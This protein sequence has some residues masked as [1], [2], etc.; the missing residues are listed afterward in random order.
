MPAHGHSREDTSKE[1]KPGLQTPGPVRRPSPH[2][3]SYS[4]NG[5]FRSAQSEER[6]PRARQRRPPRPGL[7]EWTRSATAGTR[8]NTR[9]PLLHQLQ[10]SPWCMHTSTP[11][12]PQDP[13]AVGLVPSPRA[14]LQQPTPAR[15]PESVLMACPG[16]TSCYSKNHPSQKP[17]VTIIHQRTSLC[18]NSLFSECLNLIKGKLKKKSLAYNKLLSF[19]ISGCLAALQASFG[20]EHSYAPLQTRTIS[21][22]LNKHPGQARGRRWD[23]DTDAVPFPWGPRRGARVPREGSSPRAATLS[24]C[25]RVCRSRQVSRAGPGIPG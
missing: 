6:A 19:P 7:T 24:G 18:K 5:K 10:N 21:H 14:G 20:S 4:R 22:S 12:P 3:H 25:P 9:K 1:R 16:Y 15:A 11:A 23:S 13:A 8:A 17:Q 2:R